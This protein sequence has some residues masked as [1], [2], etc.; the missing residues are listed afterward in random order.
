M[1]HHSFSFDGARSLLGLALVLIVMTGCITQIK[2]STE[3]NPKPAAEF[4][5]FN[6]FELSALKAGNPEVAEQQDAMAKI[7]ESIAKRLKTRL[8]AWNSRPV[9][10]ET[11]TLLIEPTITELKFVGG[12]GRF[13]GGA[14]AGSSAVVMRAKFTERETGKAIAHPE[15]YARAAAMGGAYSF[16]GTDNA[17]LERIANSLAVYVFTNYKQS[18]GGPV[19]PTEVEASSISTD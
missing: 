1:K 16:G 6:R 19:M 9:R 14:L 4:S 7:Q 11:R 15:F 2:P 12:G 10:G 8:N 18:V 5:A 13:V 17:M 3:Q